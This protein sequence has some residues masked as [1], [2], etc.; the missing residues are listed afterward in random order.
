MK[1][2]MKYLLAILLFCS[3]LLPAKADEGMWLPMYIKMV[4]G[5]MHNLGMKLSAEDIYSINQS[6]IKD[7]IVQMGSFCTGEIVSGK[8]LV[9][10]NHHCGYDAIAELSSTESNLLD[11]GF[12]AQNFEEE[13]PVP[14]LTMSIL[15]YMMD[16]TELVNNSSDMDATI[17]SLI[18]AAETEPG[19]R[20]EI[21]SMYYGL[22]HYLLVYQVF[23]DIR[24]VGAPPSSIGKFGGDTDNWM[25]PRHTGDFSIFRIYADADNNPAEYSEDNIPYTPKHFLPISL[26]GV[27]ENDFSMI[28]GFPGSTERYISSFAIDQL[29]QTDYPAFVK[30]LGE[31]LAI[32]KVEMD[33]DP[34]LKLDIASDYASLSNS[35]KY[36]KGVVEGSSKSDFIDKKRELEAQFQKWADADESRTEEYG[37]VLGELEAKYT[38]GV[39]VSK[40]NDYVNYAGFGTS[41]VIYGINFFRLNR[42]MK[43]DAKQ[44]DYQSMLDEISSTMG[45]YFDTYS[46][47]TDQKVIA[48]TL[49][50]MYTD[51]STDY[52]LSLFE[53]A[54]FKKMKDNSK[55][56]RFDNYAAYL[57]KKSMLAD[58]NKM[59]KFL[60]KP[61][62]KKLLADP[63]VEYTLSVIDLYLK[64]SLNFQIHTSIIEDLMKTYMKGIREMQAGTTFYPDADFSLRMTYGSVKSYFAEGAG[65]YNYWTDHYGILAKEKPG[66]EEF[67]VDKKLHDLLVNKDF[68]DYARNDTLPVCFIT[69]TDITGGNSGSPVIDAEGNLIGIAFDGNWEAMISDIYFVEEVTRTISVDIRYVMFIIDKYAGA[70]RLV[71]EVTLIR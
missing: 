33:K 53:S 36:F 54:T 14:G 66:D 64:N 71:D 60:K 29:I 68:G 62:H 63:G 2:S 35:Y 28:M 31:R 7:A 49:R 18:V 37:N 50:M 26:K 67:D 27:K 9:F 4:S 5:N 24:M 57:M 58:E 52:H 11:G 59:S 20:A 34:K 42:M 16:V 21:S 23:S 1:K 12:W 65:K 8:G 3:T 55:G 41:M 56:D 47:Q 40:Y 32:M 13:M 25:W 19:Y 45:P 15:M 38:E 46:K 30:I 48:A 22:E 17:D 39:E 44:E 61:S 6:S 43:D 10:T 51:L 69:N 70:Q